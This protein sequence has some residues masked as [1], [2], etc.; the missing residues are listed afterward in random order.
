VHVGTTQGTPGSARAPGGT[1]APVTR[2]VEGV[3]QELEVDPEHIGCFK[4]APGAFLLCAF[5]GGPQSSRAKALAKT[6]T[7]GFYAGLATSTTCRAVLGNNENQFT[8]EHAS[9][10]GARWCCD[11]SAG[12]Y[13]V[14][15]VSANLS[16]SHV[17]CTDSTMTASHI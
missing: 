17:A 2:G 6:L 13:C 3:G 7:S 15:V 8:N 14:F 5:L 11:T 16:Q 12:E 4:A 9:R 1:C 10:Q